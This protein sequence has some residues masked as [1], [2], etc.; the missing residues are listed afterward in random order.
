MAT[1]PR[2]AYTREVPPTMQ[3]ALFSAGFPLFLPKKEASL[4]LVLA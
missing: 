3:E 2:G 4:R 1:I